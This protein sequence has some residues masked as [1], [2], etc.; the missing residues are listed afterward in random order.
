VAARELLAHRLAGLGLQ[1]WP[2]DANFLLVGAPG[3]DAAGFAAG[4]RAAGIGVR[5]FPA[6]P[7]A[8]DCVRITVGPEPL[9]DRLLART[10]A[11]LRS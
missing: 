6:L 3:G 9:M 1:V 4:V 8:G 10:E 5:P 2:S 11:L 7:L